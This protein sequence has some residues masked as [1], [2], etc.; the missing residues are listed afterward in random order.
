ML[1]SQMVKKGEGI[2]ALNQS[3]NRD[4]SIFDNPDK[5]NIQRSPNPQ[6]STAC[7]LAG[8]RGQGVL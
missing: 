2:I 5:F 1:S 6:V 4:E 3:A 7:A 8:V